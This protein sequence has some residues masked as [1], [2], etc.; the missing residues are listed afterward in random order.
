MST[1]ELQHIQQSS[2]L[3]V[4][5]DEKDISAAER[6]AIAAIDDASDIES[7]ADAAL[8]AFRVAGYSS[9]DNDNR[10]HMLRAACCAHGFRMFGNDA[11]AAQFMIGY[12]AGVSA[13]GL[14]LQASSKEHEAAYFA[15]RE[16]S[17]RW[18]IHLA[19]K[20]AADAHLRER[21]GSVPAGTMK[22]QICWR[23]AYHNA[24]TRGCQ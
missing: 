21:F 10:L 19:A 15:G 2:W 18:V 24:C 12:I 6:A 11:D 8:A 22:A 16:A 13:D 3:Y 7:G 20:A 5:V 9:L 4:N 14:E 1:L 17:P 23:R